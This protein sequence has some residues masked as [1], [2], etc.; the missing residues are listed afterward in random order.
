V[1]APSPTSMVWGVRSIT[2]RA[3]ETA[4][5]MSSSAQTAPMSPAQ[6]MTQA[7]QRHPPV[8][9]RQAAVTDGGIA[10]V[11]LSHP[12]ARLD[13]VQRRAAGL[14]RRNAGGVGRSA[15]IPGRDHDGGGGGLGRHC[16]GKG[17]HGSR[18]QNRTAR[19]AH[20]LTD[21]SA[22]LNRP[23]RSPSGVNPLRLLVC[24]RATASSQSRAASSLRPARII[25]TTWFSL[26]LSAGRST[27]EKSINSSMVRVG[28]RASV[29]SIKTLDFCTMAS[30][31]PSLSIAAEN[32]GS[33]KQ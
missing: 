8:A 24:F 3:T 25:A 29:S 2:R 28:T 22:R 23:A 15:E 31:S 12:A 5:T 7:S 17:G 6:V 10:L 20:Q 14:T 13:H 18:S 21:L 30:T 33:V 32:I 19:L 27:P 4:W 11:R 26:T 16:R 9:V 1:R